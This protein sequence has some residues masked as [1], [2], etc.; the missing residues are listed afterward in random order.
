MPY[1]HLVIICCHAIY[2]GG[3][4]NGLSENE[5]IIEPFQ[6]GETPTFTNHIKAG[7]QLLVNDPS[8]L[9]MFSGGPTKRPR[10]EISEGESYHNLAQDNDYFGFSAQI[11]PARVLVE[12]HATDSYQNVLFSL[13]R[14]RLVMG[15]YPGR[16]TIVTHEFKRGRFEECHFPALGLGLRGRVQVQVVGINPPEEVTSLDSLVEGEEKSGIG[17][18]RG[19]RY[20]VQRELMGKRVKR[21]WKM[22]M[23][24]GVFVN[25]GLEEVVEELVRWDGGEMG[26]EWF[27]KMDQ[28][29]WC[30]GGD[31][32]H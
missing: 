28:L 8:A 1:T 7:L 20:G 21:G 4:T 31:E 18:W 32:V 27:P 9:L 30:C 10:T 6:K 11:D 3:P 19:D 5:W 23:E 22:G 24:E 26:N 15:R 29:P 17:L 16:V 13:L 12:A 2:T 14:F 25:V